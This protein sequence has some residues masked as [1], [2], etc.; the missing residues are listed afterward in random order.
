MKFI[1]RL[2]TRRARYIRDLQNAIDQDQ[3][4]RQTSI[5]REDTMDCPAMATPFRKVL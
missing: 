1:R 4:R 2:L 5:W 3:R